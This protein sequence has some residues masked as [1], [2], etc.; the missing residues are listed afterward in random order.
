MKYAAA[1]LIALTLSA[2]T[3]SQDNRAREQARQDVDHA[4]EDA[5]EAL[6]K[7]KIETQKASRELD[8]DLHKAR[9]KA[10]QAL[11]QPAK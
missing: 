9:E 8:V 6:R 5:K 2:C 11:D 3:P 7:A 4:R 1:I 10:R